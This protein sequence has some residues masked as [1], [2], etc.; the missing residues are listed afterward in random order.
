M[1][2]CADDSCGNT[3]LI[4]SRR[5]PNAEN[6]RNRWNDRVR[7]CVCALSRSVTGIHVSLWST[8]VP[9]QAGPGTK[10]LGATQVREP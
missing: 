10:G 2:P 8:L 5:L 7:R 6:R 3:M 1:K 4:H 9:Q